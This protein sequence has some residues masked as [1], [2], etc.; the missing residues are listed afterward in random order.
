MKNQPKAQPPKK[1]QAVKE[2][3][4]EWK[5]DDYVSESVSLEQVRDVKAAFD[6]FD[7]DGSGLV[8]ANQLKQAFVSLGLADANKLVYHIMHNL[9]GDHPNGLNFAEFLKLATGRLGET[10]NR[11]EIEKVFASFDHHHTVNKL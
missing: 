5:A 9:D 10:Q 6:I 11:K 1:P 4:K 2:E 7:N 8:D 3:P